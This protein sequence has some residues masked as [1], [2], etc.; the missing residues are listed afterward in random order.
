MSDP[1]D[2]PLE[3]DYSRKSGPDNDFVKYLR[4]AYEEM[5]SRLA[6]HER[7]AITN[8]TSLDRT[9]TLHHSFIARK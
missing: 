9:H 3:I 1:L 8:V 4:S 7:S 6:L 5:V 2:N